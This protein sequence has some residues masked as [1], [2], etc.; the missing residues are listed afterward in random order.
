MKYFLTVLFNIL[1][2]YGVFL[3]GSYLLDKEKMSE[4]YA[5]PNFFLFILV[6]VA[7]NTLPWVLFVE[8]DDKLRLKQFQDGGWND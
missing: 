3:I 5:F 1:S 8:Q 7:I 6:M 4:W 2:F